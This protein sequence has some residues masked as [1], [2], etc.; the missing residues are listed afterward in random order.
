MAY[1]I[2]RGESIYLKIDDTAI[3][4]LTQADYSSSAEEIDST[5]KNTAGTKTT[6][7][8]AISAS[9]S[10]GGNYT[11]GTGSNKD[12]HTI[13]AAHLART[14]VSAKWGGLDTG[15][16]TYTADCK[17]LSVSA[18]APNTGGLVTW[19]AELK[20]YGAVTVATIS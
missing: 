6:E 18:S 8:G 20:A 12:F 7:V 13:H 11:E 9:F 17:I 10:I 15:D 4:C 16:K 19:T 2:Q 3:E 5:C 1:T 14:T